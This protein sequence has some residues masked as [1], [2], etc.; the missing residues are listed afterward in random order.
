MHVGGCRLRAALCSR[1]RNCPHWEG[2][3]PQCCGLGDGQLDL[4]GMTYR[5]RT[6]LWSSEGRTAERRRQ[7]AAEAAWEDSW[8]YSEAMVHLLAH[9]RQRRSRHHS[10]DPSLSCTAAD[11]IIEETAPDQG[12]LVGRRRGEVSPGAN[13]VHSR[14]SWALQ[15]KC[16]GGAAEV[17]SA[18]R[19][20]GGGCCWLRLA[21]YG[22]LEG[23]S[24]TE[25]QRGVRDG[26]KGLRSRHSGVVGCGVRWRWPW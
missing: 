8:Y 19:E 11:A 1:I 22:H 24:G 3:E 10:R 13:V 20:G 21:R 18:R 15:D 5:D 7:W 23:E 16:I 6:A 2:A 4:G 9:L 17:W 25:K 12:S 14:W 26:A